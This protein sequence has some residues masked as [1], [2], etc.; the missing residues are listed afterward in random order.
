MFLFH[1]HNHQLSRKPSLF[2]YLFFA[3]CFSVSTPAH[4][5]LPASY[6]DLNTPLIPE[7]I[8][9]SDDPSE[10]LPP[11]STWIENESERTVYSSSYKTPDGQVVLRYSKKP[12]NYH[13]KSGRLVPID[14]IMAPDA[15]GWS[16]MN[17]PYP[18]FHNEDGTSEISLGDGKRMKL[19]QGHAIN[20]L[21]GS[22]DLVVGINNDVWFKNVIP[23]ID[24]HVLFF[25]NAIK[26][27]YII[28]Q[29]PIVSGTF[30]KFSEVVTL[31]KGY[32]FGSP[33]ETELESGSE[34]DIVIYDEKLRIVARFC[35]PLCYDANKKV[36]KAGYSLTATGN[37]GTLEILV[38]VSWLNDPSRAYPVVI[39]PL[40]IGPTSTWSGGQ[41]PS[42][43]T[44]TYNA[45][46][47]LITVPAAISVT[48]FYVTSSYYADPFTTAVMSNGSLRFRTS[49]ATSTNF[50]VP[51]PQG[52]TPGTA[53]L[54]SFDLKNPLMCCMQSSCST[55][56]FWLTM[57]LGRNAPST[58]CN[59][60]YIRY[61]TATLWPFSALVVGRTPE[62]YG[63]QWNVPAA[64]VCRNR[65]TI[66]CT[67]YVRYGVPPFTITHPWM[68]NP[69]VA[70]TLNSG[71]SSGATQPVITLTVPGCPVYCDTV[72][73]MVVP[74]PVITDACGQVVTGIPPGVLN[75]KPAP[76]ITVTPDTLTICSGDSFNL[77][78]SSCIPAAT[79]NWFG[80]SMT[81][82]GNIIDGYINNTN[83]AYASSY[84]SY[85]LFNGCYSD[86]AVTWVT[87]DPL[88]LGAF[89]YIPTPS[90]ANVPLDFLDISSIY[91]GNAS[92]W[93][94]NFGD[95]T[96]SNLQNPS[97]TYTVPGPY[98]VCLTVT[99]NNGCVD[100][101]CR[102]IEVIA[103]DVIVPNVV[104][105]N[106]DA[107]NDN[108]GFQYLEFFAE[109]R[110]EVYNR[111]GNLIFSKDGYMNDW[112]PSKFSNGT[113]YYVLV[114]DGLKKTYAGFFEVLH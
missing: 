65:C 103:P 76:D 21:K 27:N 20:G 6:P 49:C 45:D 64:P 66:A 84:S 77:S 87:V 83:A 55:R 50:T 1:S 3:F 68:L 63:L 7:T 110:L 39:D 113:Y 29:Q 86:T 108:L 10:K 72:T 53:Y 28:R 16:A 5:Q 99:T 104:T 74:P 67:T 90:L 15:N 91:A 112:S 105:P 19:N 44:P 96:T 59:L 35:T 56:T 12:I 69:I 23:D 48:A 93:L 109:N 51:N 88:P 114:V 92:T 34:G 32:Q 38:P 79:L 13:D 102:I 80:N 81:G 57:L 61:N 75:L 70:G 82:T 17:Q 94:W 71:C 62:A 95:N 111:W 30:M 97:H 98:T 18:V 11:R 25:E 24:K 37:I 42:C 2:H 8:I 100:S 47:I 101:V 31:P 85:A 9:Q 43:I 54:D 106:G 73:S 40:V 58:G 78:L 22:G 36:L 107:M 60:T 41:M 33:E 14:P 52:N 26:Y 89:N 46:S 4:P